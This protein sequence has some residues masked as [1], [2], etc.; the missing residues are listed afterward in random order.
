MLTEEYC[1]LDNMET[2]NI[3][4]CVT[5]VDHGQYNITQEADE[6][7]KNSGFQASVAAS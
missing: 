6:M 3:R 5:S 1:G 4:N 7:N 2:R